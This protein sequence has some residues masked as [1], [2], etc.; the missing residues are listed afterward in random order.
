MM[1]QQVIMLQVIASSIM[2]IWYRKVSLKYPQKIFLTSLAIYVVVALAGF[3]ISFL[4]NDLAVP[5]VPKG[6]ALGYI[7]GEGILIPL[8]WLFSYKLL[9]IIGASSMAVAQTINFLTTAVFGVLFL[10]DP[11]SIAILVGGSLLISGVILALTIKRSSNQNSEHSTSF[12]SM[13]LALSSIA[14]ALALMFEKLAIDSIG[15]WDYAL[16]GWAAQLVGALVLFGIF[17]RKEL[18]MSAPFD[19]WK[20]ASIAGLLTAVSGSLF[21]YSLSKGLLSSVIL[22]SSA[23]VA[24]TAFLGFWLLHERNKLGRRLAAVVFSIFGLL[25]IFSA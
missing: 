7:I 10:G 17:G 5:H 23:K 1:W 16:Y 15:V 8:S 25:V 2:T 19:F 4:H 24:L 18:T 21:I 9:S 6:L 20:K 13:L 11:F 22:A 12:K 3:A 14:L